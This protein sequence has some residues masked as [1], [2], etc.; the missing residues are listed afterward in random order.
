M[1]GLRSEKLQM[2]FQMLRVSGH[3]AKC[4]SKIEQGKLART[5]DKSPGVYIAL[6]GMLSFE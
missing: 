5:S 2:L 1:R 6:G 4:K 3:F